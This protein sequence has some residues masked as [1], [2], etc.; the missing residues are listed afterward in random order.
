MTIDHDALGRQLDGEPHFMLLARDDLAPGMVALYAALR[1]RKTHAVSDI[2]RNL[3][4]TAGKMPYHPK[5]DPEH[6]T[7]AQQVSN[8][9]M[10][11]QYKNRPK[12]PSN[13]R[14]VELNIS[15]TGEA[16]DTESQQTDCVVLSEVP[17]GEL[18]GDTR[19]EPE[20]WR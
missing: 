12:L 15:T 5:D 19:P 8:A 10:L 3:V 11:W 4:V 18:S 9:M 16:R 6:A 2:V 13:A 20:E 1:G 14:G 17:G 7:S